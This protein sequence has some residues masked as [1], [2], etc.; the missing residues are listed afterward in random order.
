M[1]NLLFVVVVGLF[2]GAASGARDDWTRTASV[3]PGSRVIVNTVSGEENQGT[4]RS[5]GP[6]SVS[7]IVNGRD[8]EIQRSE[9]ARIRVYTRSR[10]L[11]NLL[12]WAGI[13]AA[14][15]MLAGVATCPSCVGDPTSED[16]H[17]RLVLGGLI[18][19]GA[20]AGAGLLRSP[21]K[22]VY[23]RRR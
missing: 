19:A 15:G 13:G 22:T 14:A 10:R 8:L 16:A 1:K 21:F 3:A 11:R 4:F 20:G 9:V 17:R 6:D 12:I 5:A 7:L 2:V 18:G 23:R